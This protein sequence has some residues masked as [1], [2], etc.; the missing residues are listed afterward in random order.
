M[1]SGW[2][3]QTVRI[4]RRGEELGH[5][6]RRSHILRGFVPGKQ[7]PE[8]SAEQMCGQKRTMSVGPSDTKRELCSGTGCHHVLVA[9]AG[10]KRRL[11]HGQGMEQHGLILGSSQTSHFPLLGS[12]N[13]WWLE[14]QGQSMWKTLLDMHFHLSSHLPPQ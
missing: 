13:M 12:G 9:P 4:R 5:A 14:S 10:P 3:V 7:E 6:Q 2:H 1:A 11:L 8:T